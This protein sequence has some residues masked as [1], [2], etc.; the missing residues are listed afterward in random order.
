VVKYGN[1]KDIFLPSC[2]WSW[3]FVTN[4]WRGGNPGQR[5]GEREKERE[6]KREFALIKTKETARRGGARL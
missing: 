1:Q 5:E 2:L 3:S 4:T 6:S